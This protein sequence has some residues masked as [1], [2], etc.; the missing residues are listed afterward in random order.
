MDIRSEWIGFGKNSWPPIKR[1]KGVAVSARF[2]VIKMWAKTDFL[3]DLQPKHLAQLI[4]YDKTPCEESEWEGIWKIGGK[5]KQEWEG[6]RQYVD[7]EEEM[8]W[9]DDCEELLPRLVSVDETL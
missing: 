2:P 6:Q 9:D 3:N 7:E 8:I 4:Y 5:F 1:L